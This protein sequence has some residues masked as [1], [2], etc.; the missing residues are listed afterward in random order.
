[1][2]SRMG[3]PKHEIVLPDGRTMIHAV[4][5][6]LSTVCAR[7]VV[8][9][10]PVLQQLVPGIVIIEDMR[11]H[12]GPLGGIEALLSSG[13]D[14]QYLICACDVPRIS[15]ELLRSLIESPTVA[16]AAVP[17]VAG[18]DHPEPLPARLSVQALPVVRRLLDQGEH[19]VWKLMRE[20]SAIEI[21]IPAD[22][23]NQLMNINT[24]EDLEELQLELKARSQQA[25]S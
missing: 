16:A 18:S 2:S 4:I 10:S 23:S 15:P 5:D 8:V 21:S 20:L 24:P 3:R 9:G 14:S 11:A 7:V 6:V 13:I 1:M 25:R 17:R 19:A 22:W 12:S